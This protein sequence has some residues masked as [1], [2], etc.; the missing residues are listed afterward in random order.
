[1]KC[2]TLISDLNLENKNREN[3]TNV[4]KLVLDTLL[5][6]KKILANSNQNKLPVNSLLIQAQFINKIE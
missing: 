4:N 3:A 6:Q 1:M 5:S 2:E